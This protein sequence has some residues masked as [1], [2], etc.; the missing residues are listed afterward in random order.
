MTLSARQKNI[1]NP[2]AENVSSDTR[3]GTG[4]D[5]SLERNKFI[6]DAIHEQFV[7]FFNF[8]AVGTVLQNVEY[9]I[10][11]EDVLAYFALYPQNG[12]V[13]DAQPVE[14][15]AAESQRMLEMIA[16]VLTDGKVI[17]RYTSK[18][19]EESLLEENQ[20]GTRQTVAQLIS[21]PPFHSKEYRNNLRSSL[22]LSQIQYSDNVGLNQLNLEPEVAVY[23]SSDSNVDL[24]DWTQNGLP[25]EDNDRVYYNPVDSHY[26]YV[27]RTNMVDNSSMSFVSILQRLAKTENI[28]AA[29]RYWSTLPQDFKEVYTSAINTSVR[30][31]LKLSERASEENFNKLKRMMT[32]P[33][34]YADV[35]V[36]Q[37]SDDVFPLM[38]YKDIRPGSRWVYALKID[39]DFVS[40]LRVSESDL[41]PSQNEYQLTPIEKAKALIG[42]ENHSSTSISF[43]ILELLRNLLPVRNCLRSVADQLA[44]QGLTPEVLQGINLSQEAS[45]LA[46]FFE[47]LE[48]FYNYNNIGIEEQDRVQMFMRQDYSLDHIVINGN[49]YYHG[50]GRNNYFDSDNEEVSIINAFGLYSSTTFSI[51]QKSEEI[52]N[53]VNISDHD[54]DPFEF[55]NYYVYPKVNLSAVSIRQRNRSASS[56]DSFLRKQTLFTKISE[57]SKTD[58][59]QFERLYDKRNRKFRVGNLI[60]D[61]DCNTGQ[62][63]AAKYALKFYEAINGKTKVQS[64]IRETILLLR[65]EV[66]QDELTR[67]LLGDTSRY[68]DDYLTQQRRN[69]P[70]DEREYLIEQERYY[71]YQQVEKYVNDQMFCGLD[72]LP[73][74]IENSLLDPSGDPPDPSS[75]SK[76]PNDLV[77]TIELKKTKMISL[78]A[79]QSEIYR[80]ALETI[81]ANFIKSLVAGV[82]KDIMNA[83][84]G[85]GPTASSKSSTAG[86]KDIA[87]QTNFGGSDLNA[88]AE[89]VDLVSIAKKTPLYSVKVEQVNGIETRILSTPRGDQLSALLADISRMCTPLEAQQLL[90][91][92]AT[93]DLI[94][95]LLETIT[96]TVIISSVDID[97]SFYNDIE[98]NKENI[99]DFFIAIGESLDLNI[100]SV[101]ENSPIAAYCKNQKNYL[102]SSLQADDF[103][104][105]LEEQYNR[106]VNAKLDKINF[107]CDWLRGLQNLELRL[108]RLLS[109]LPEM[110]WYDDMLRSIAEVSNSLADMVSQFFR[111]LFNQEETRWQREKGEYNLYNSKMG[112]ELFYQIFFPMRELAINQI[113]TYQGENGFLTPS[114]WSPRRIGFGI[115]QDPDDD[116]ELEWRGSF[117]GR[118]NSQCSNTTFSYIWSDNRANVDTY[119]EWL[120]DPNRDPG[121]R[122]PAGSM[123]RITEASRLGLPQFIENPQPQYDAW[124]TAYYSVKTSPESV[125]PYLRPLLTQANLSTI[126]QPN[127]EAEDPR[128]RTAAERTF[129]TRLA[130]RLEN[131][132]TIEE[133]TAPF[134]GWTGASYLE[135]QTPNITIS[136]FNPKMPATVR[137]LRNFS[138]PAFKSDE[139]AKYYPGLSDSVEPGTGVNYQI[140][141]GLQTENH[142]ISLNDVPDQEYLIVDDI[143]MPPLSSPGYRELWGKLSVGVYDNN[144]GNTSLLSIQNYSQRIDTQINSS[145][146]SDAGS[147]NMTKYLRSLNESPFINAGDECVTPQDIAK[148][149]AGIQVIQS[150]MFGF[151]LNIMPLTVLYPKWGSLGTIKLITDYLYRKISE[152]IE[153]TGLT[154]VLYQ[155]FDFIEKVY[156]KNDDIEELRFNPSISADNTAPEN[157]K[158]IIEAMYVGLLNNIAKN[159]QFKRINQTAIDSEYRQ[160]LKLI[161]QHLSSPGTDLQP[162]Q[163][164]AGRVNGVKQ[165]INQFVNGEEITE[166]G[167]LVS[168][169]FAPVAFQIASYFVYM[170]TGIKFSER[171]SQ[172]FL[173]QITMVAAADD[174][175]ATV[176]KGQSIYLYSEA[177]RNFP[178]IVRTF[179]TD[180]NIQYFRPREVNLRLSQLDLYMAGFSVVL[181]D[182]F[183][184]FTLQRLQ[185]IQEN[186]E[187]SITGTSLWR[188]Y[189]KIYSDERIVETNVGLR[190]VLTQTVA[191]VDSIFNSWAAP[192][193][194]IIEEE[195]DPA[196]AAR[197]LVL[198]RDLVVLRL[199]RPPFGPD[200][201]A[202]EEQVR[203]LEEEISGIEALQR[204]RIPFNYNRSLE[205]ATQL[206]ASDNIPDLERLAA[207]T[208]LDILENNY[209]TNDIDVLTPVDYYR[210]LALYFRALAEYTRE[211]YFQ[212]VG[213]LGPLDITPE[214]T[215]IAY[216]A[217]FIDYLASVYENTPDVGPK[218]LLEKTKL[219]KLINTNE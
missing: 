35:D 40:S 99:V 91:G 13:L 60:K 61:M 54:M 198:Q 137:R 106:I 193:F 147:Q 29:I 152:D 93:L 112:T 70:E 48:L 39:R 42:P 128:A 177:I 192:D 16:R 165:K 190:Q 155:T 124:D 37:K 79:S 87:S 195:L 182:F 3:R 180:R 162:F 81:I 31:I 65:Q 97:P 184:T 5:Y 164:G 98:F 203:L 142:T 143:V 173:Q 183:G 85:C 156:G 62:A 166:L 72:V 116:D 113:F 125:Y 175:L 171:Y 211:R 20:Q 119:Q 101:V 169:Y 43:N 214:M 52:Y 202:W 32:P 75:L 28:E 22:G 107:L 14:I 76:R 132:W 218:L 157:M 4:Y 216:A 12:K 174:N 187:T 141:N 121:D 45:K 100:D 167:M 159:D 172:T 108:Q 210:S 69:T 170:D 154:G 123:G 77:P 144:R 89:T 15:A 158:N 206:A 135:C 19:S 73:D 2:Y 7:Y 55:L 88:A 140:F 111:D 200:L 67:R 50:C 217:S 204:R 78:K 139:V 148:A 58:P 84:F 118:R 213:E 105:V 57:L 179:E 9:T 11:E 17:D 114:C 8:P 146:I 212:E 145:V 199:Q 94:E 102:G 115:G 92:E 21:I 51:L 104:I 130:N 96:S 134:L 74:F 23:M 163:I 59:R 215:A 126:G 194:D 207:Q 209:T 63:R 95:H 86:L 129:L 127:E 138:E 68:L 10:T 80:K 18:T 110:T 150:R 34:S 136:Y 151:F 181:E 191:E 189:R 44:R 122:P 46:S 27:K 205:D 208:W 201:A 38:V 109:L 219:E 41:R 1:V 53:Q 185:Q 131:Y 49:F 26:Y 64:L 71:I 24:Y 133:T 188:N 186:P 56:S 117:G 82:V 176:I 25:G 197:L 196:Q 161:Y 6:L 66:I 90:D 33:T 83:L 149:D 30:E 47:L 120:N 36:Q 178:A 168:P 103:N 153:Q 160:G